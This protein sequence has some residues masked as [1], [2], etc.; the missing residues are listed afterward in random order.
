MNNI[1]EINLK[2]E[3]SECSQDFKEGFLKYIDDFLDEH[4]WEQLVWSGY[5][6]ITDSRDYHYIV[7]FGKSKA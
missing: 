7:D 1:K 6:F 4:I 3:L 5:N 2:I